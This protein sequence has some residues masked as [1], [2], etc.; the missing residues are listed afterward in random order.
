[1]IDWERLGQYIRLNE[2]IYLLYDLLEVEEFGKY[3]VVIQILSDRLYK[4]IRECYRNYKHVVSVEERMN[5]DKVDIEEV[6]EEGTG[7]GSLF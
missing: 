1:M 7:I 2:L 6:E 5:L 3:K 4:K